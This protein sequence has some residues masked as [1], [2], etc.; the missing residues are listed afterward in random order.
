MGGAMLAANADG[1]KSSPY[2]GQSQSRSGRSNGAA[3][4]LPADEGG[5]MP[6]RKQHRNK[7]PYAID[8]SDE[9][10]DLLTALPKNNRQEESLADFLRNNEPPEDNAPRPIMNGNSAR[11]RQPMGRS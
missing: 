11:L 10:E 5:T 3:P 6:A 7:D 1:T 4:A 9:D 8:Y 2:D